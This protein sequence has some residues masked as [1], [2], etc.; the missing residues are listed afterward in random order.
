MEYVDKLYV[1]IIK[2]IHYNHVMM[3]IILISMDVQVNVKYNQDI[4]VYR[5]YL[6][7][8]LLIFGSLIVI[9]LRILKLMLYLLIN[10]L[11]RIKLKL[12]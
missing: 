6:I 9:L 5:N 12:Y 7:L 8:V 4:I 11:I 2:L 1:V 3:E 10:M